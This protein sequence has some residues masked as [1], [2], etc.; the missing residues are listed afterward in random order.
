MR[1]SS[2]TPSSLGFELESTTDARGARTEARAVSARIQVN[3]GVQLVETTRTTKRRAASW[4]A[5][6]PRDIERFE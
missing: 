5:L 1:V 3:N 4:R 2:V 6:Q